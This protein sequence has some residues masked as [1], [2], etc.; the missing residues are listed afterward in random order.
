MMDDSGDTREDI[1]LPDSDLGR[2]IKDKFDKGDQI[3]V[4]V[5]AACGEEMAIAVKPMTK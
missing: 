3:M 1:K 5:L 4:T 2:D